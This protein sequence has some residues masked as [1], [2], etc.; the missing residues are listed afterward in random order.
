MSSERSVVGKNVR[1]VDGFQLVTGRPAFTDDISIPG[2]LYG[3]ILPSPHAHAR[4]KRIDARK[5]R[6]LA[7]VHAVLTY[8]D[9]PR[10]P[11]T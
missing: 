4:I 8:R 3:K 5:A 7:G 2:M 9:V 6:A 11:H 1:K 10:V